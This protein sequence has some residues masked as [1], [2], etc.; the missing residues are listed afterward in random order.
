MARI[1]GVFGFTGGFLMISPD[2]R[3][4]LLAGIHFADS[5]LQNY[6]PYSYLAVAVIVLIRQKNSWVTS[7][8]GSLPSEW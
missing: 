3:Q 4:G 7:G 5:F 6:S 1:L 2:L 8:S